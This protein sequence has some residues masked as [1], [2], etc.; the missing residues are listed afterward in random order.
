[1]T[2]PDTD[3][4]FE[5]VPELNVIEPFAAPPE[6]DDFSLTYIFVFETVPA[7]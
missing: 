5:A 2:V 1:M 3:T 7:F 4:E 6:T